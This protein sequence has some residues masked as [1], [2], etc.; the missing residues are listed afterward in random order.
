VLGFAAV[1]AF[2]LAWVFALFGGPG[3]AFFHPLT[4]AFL[5]LALLAAHLVL[6]SWLPWRKGAA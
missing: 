3:P 6:G 2:V 4:L 1:L 5:G